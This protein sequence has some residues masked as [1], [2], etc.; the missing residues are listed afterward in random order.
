VPGDLKT[1]LG[2][3]LAANNRSDAESAYYNGLVDSD[4]V[5]INPMPE[6]L[7]YDVLM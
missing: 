4:L 7:P 1:R 6:G 3:E 2:E 5:T